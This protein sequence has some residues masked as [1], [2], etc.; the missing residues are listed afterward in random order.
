[1]KNYQPKVSIVIPVYNG[2][3]YLDESIQSALCQTYSNIEVIVVNDGS[4][5]NGATEVVAQKYS[6]RIFYFSKE[7][8]GV[9]SALNMG[10]KKATG[11]WISWLSHDDLYY[12]QKIEKQI[13]LLNKIISEKKDVDLSRTVVFCDGEL[14]KANGDFLR[15]Y[16][17]R[18]NH[19]QDNLELMLRN[20][21]RNYLGDNTFL[22]L[23]SCFK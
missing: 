10:I 7:N 16:D 4:C 8:G 11:E 23:I 18:Q 1:M 21:R 6:N 22:I 2:A 15:S 17:Q 5:D 13:L 3:N 12:P 20:I 19:T 9:S 14:I